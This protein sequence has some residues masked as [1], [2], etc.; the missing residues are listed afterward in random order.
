MNK[1]FS[2]KVDLNNN[3]DA[4]QKIKEIIELSNEPEEKVDQ[5]MISVLENLLASDQDI[6]ASAVARLHPSIKATSSITRSRS[7]S[8]LLT[9]YKIRQD[10]MRT[11]QKRISKESHKKFAL[12]MAEKDAEITKLKYQISLLTASHVAMI[13]AIGEL[14]GFQKW[15]QF[16]DKFKSIRDELSALAAL[17]KDVSGQSQK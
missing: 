12:K 7:R 13:R 9:Q 6:T 15:A 2:P 16:F 3:K 17:P 8:K 5:E 10:E 1:S 14:G 11:W 4:I